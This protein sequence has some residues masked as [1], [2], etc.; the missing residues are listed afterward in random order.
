MK[1]LTLLCVLYTACTLFSSTALA[2]EIVITHRS[3][4]T[5]TIRVEAGDDP[6]EQISIRKEAAA[7]PKTELKAVPPAQT[8]SQ[9][10]VTPPPSQQ[11][12]PTG[13]AK[14]TAPEPRHETGGVKIKWA[15]P[16]DAN[17]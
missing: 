3:G 7:A 1:C 6:V 16:V 14:Q 15:D 4:K 8:P 17:Y 13:T 12:A 9:T 2:D 11:A 5:Q 10:A